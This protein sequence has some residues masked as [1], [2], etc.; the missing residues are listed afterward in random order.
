MKR[1]PTCQKTYTDESLN[2][3]LD[4]GANLFHDSDSA[5]SRESGATL[6]MSGP[7]DSIEIPLP[8]QVSTP[9]GTP[10][11]V[12]PPTE[13]THND[14]PRFTAPDAY[15]ATQPPKPR[16]HLLTAGLTSIAILLLVLVGIGIALLVRDTGKNQS[17]SNN[18]G[19]VANANSSPATQTDNSSSKT[20]TNNQNSNVSPQDKDTSALNITASASSIRAPLKAFS[21][22]PANALD[23]SLLTAWIEGAPGAGIGEWIQCEFSREVKLNRVMMT[24]GYFKTAALW[25]Q[26]NRLA[27]ATLHFS[28]GSSRRFS[29]PDQ[30][31]TQTLDAGGIRTRFV[32]LVI[33]DFYPGSVDSEDTPISEMSFN[34]EP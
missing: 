14:R 17:G 2:F 33:E 9:R 13:A 31:Q 24:P 23:N 1:C 7:T 3:C 28:D 5:S 22:A 29:F 32:R 19:N 30:M 25:K 11:E 12:M 16:S 6:I 10:T 18:S 34:W 4:D 15:V 21:Y 27:A 26:N 8:T 20:N